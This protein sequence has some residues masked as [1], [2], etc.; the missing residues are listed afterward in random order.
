M[1]NFARDCR[2]LRNVL[3]PMRDGVSLATT[4]YPV[5]EVARR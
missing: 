5:A 2:I 1:T 3:V 4:V